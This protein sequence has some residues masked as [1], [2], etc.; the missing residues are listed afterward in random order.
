MTLFYLSFY[1][2]EVEIHLATSNVRRSVSTSGVWHVVPRGA[3][4]GLH[5]TRRRVSTWCTL[6]N[7]NSVLQQTA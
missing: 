5:K 1:K 3:E 2:A 4:E 7:K 6:R